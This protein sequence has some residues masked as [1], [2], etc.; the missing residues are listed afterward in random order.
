[1]TV[2]RT[3]R[4]SKIPDFVAYP[5]SKG[6]LDEWL[7]ELPQ[8][9]ISVTFSPWSA[10]TGLQRKIGTGRAEKLGIRRQKKS[11]IIQAS[12]WDFVDWRMSIYPVRKEVLQPVKELLMARNCR[13]CKIGW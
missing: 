8:D 11:L 9:S 10:D 4:R 1:M 13:A 7:S 2:L 5:I 6:H 3:S 12:Y